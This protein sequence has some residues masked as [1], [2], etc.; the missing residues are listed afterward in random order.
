MG[1]YGVGPG[2]VAGDEYG[3]SGAERRGCGGEPADGV[4]V[5]SLG[6]AAEDP[7]GS[8]RLR[9]ARDP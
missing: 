5:M 3:A 9:I 6:V 1:R 4:A 8:L 2:G 7:R